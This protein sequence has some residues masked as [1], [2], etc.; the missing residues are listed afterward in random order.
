MAQTRRIR[1]GFVRAGRTARS[2]ENLLRALGGLPDPTKG[3]WGDT[4]TNMAKRV[5]DSRAKPAWDDFLRSTLAVLPRELT[6]DPPGP[7]A[8]PLRVAR[9]LPTSDGDLRAGADD[10]RVFFRP[11][12]DD[13]AAGFADSIPDSLTKRIAFLHSDV[14]TVAVDG[15]RILN[16]PVQKFL[17]GRFVRSFGR[18]DLLRVVIR[19]LPELPVAHGSAEAMECAEILNWA[20]KLVGEA[21]PE[22]LLPLLGRLPVACI[23]GWFAMS[24]AVFG[25]AW[26][27]RSGDHL[28]T[29]ADGLPGAEGEML[30]R[31]ALLPPDDERRA[32][33][34]EERRAAADSHGIDLSDRGD[35]LARAGVVDGLRLE[36]CEPIRFWMGKASPKLPDKA[37]PGIPQAAWGHWRE[38]AQGEVK[39]KHKGWFKYDLKNV[40]TLSPL[41]QND[42]RNTAR[43]ALSNLILASLPHWKEGWD[44]VTIAKVKDQPFK[45]QI[46]SPLKHW[47]STVPWLVD[48]SNPQALRGDPQPLHRRWLV[49]KSLLQGQSGRFRHLSPLSLQLARRLGEDEELLGALE[50]LGLNVYPTDDDTTG[51]A[52]LEALADV[53]ETL[54]DGVGPTGHQAMP[55]GGFDVLLGQVRHAWRHLD[56]EP[57]DPLPTRFIVRTKPRTLTVRTA[58]ELKDIYLPGHGWRT[59]LLRDHAKPIVAMR[60]QEAGGPIGDRLVELGARRATGLEERCLIDGRPSAQAVEGTQTLAAAGLGWLPVVLLA[61]HAHGGGNPAGPATK[62]WRQAAKRLRRARVRQC[63]TIEVEL[64][65]SGRSVCA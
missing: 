46:T 2:V 13:A 5:K 49:P 20:L 30:L 36:D 27:G 38:V 28:K 23:G 14:K 65:D 17:D 11:R 48:D 41:H 42:I 37:P 56:T 47:L 15:K 21:E 24:D 22:R 40:K 53:A 32:G 61:L 9:F 33:R 31:S 62:A 50:G 10:V 1:G 39:P 51:P 52:L 7:A 54:A 59:R 35:Q 44:K 18:E 4:L 45:Q 57:R 64:R 58:D 8:D 12:Q 26:D 3:E 25:P 34:R 29:L 19:S 16:T 60:P 63:L 55:A 43:L 6:A